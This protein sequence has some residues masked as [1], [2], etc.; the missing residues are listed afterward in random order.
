MVLLCL[1][2]MAVVFRGVEKNTNQ[3]NII[4]ETQ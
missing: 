4:L 2:Y 3:V 1:D